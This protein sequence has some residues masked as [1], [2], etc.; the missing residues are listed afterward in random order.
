MAEFQHD[1]TIGDWY[2]QA[3]PEGLAK[4]DVMTRNARAAH[5]NKPRAVRYRE[6]GDF[7]TTQTLDSDH[8]HQLL[9]SGV[10][11]IRGPQ[12]NLYPS[13]SQPADVNPASYFGNPQVLWPIGPGLAPFIRRPVIM[14]QAVGFEIEKTAPLN[15]DGIF[16][17]GTPRPLEDYTFLNW[18]GGLD[19]SAAS[20]TS[21]DGI[22]YNV[23]ELNLGDNFMRVCAEIPTAVTQTGQAGATDLHIGARFRIIFGRVDGTSNHPGTGGLCTQPMPRGYYIHYQAMGPVAAY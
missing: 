9:L 20:G 6:S 22:S 13:A 11:V 17:V 10:R 23:N 19:W 8:T 1:P 21:P 7:T 15:G 12:Q 4:L 5:W 16:C 14:S 3:V 18:F 2:F